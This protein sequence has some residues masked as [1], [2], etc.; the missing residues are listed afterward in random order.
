MMNIVI[1][2]EVRLTWNVSSSV[3][4]AAP[5]ATQTTCGAGSSRL[6]L[7]KQTGNSQTL[8]STPSARLLLERREH[9][10]RE[11]VDDEH[12]DQQQPDGNGVADTALLLRRVA[13]HVSSK[14]PRGLGHALPCPFRGRFS[15]TASGTV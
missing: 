1:S 4:G 8:G 11:H 15:R 12:E 9:Q 13:R 7:M 5:P 14:Q 10:E 6:P 2:D 3:L